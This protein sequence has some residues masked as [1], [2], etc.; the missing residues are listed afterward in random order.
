MVDLNIKVYGE[1]SQDRATCTI[2]HN[3]KD[4]L[5]I[6]KEFSIIINHIRNVISISEYICFFNRHFPIG[7]KQNIETKAH[8]IT[9]HMVW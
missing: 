9:V 6:Y 5:N 4:K 2:W 1:R 7:Y 3:V 8:G